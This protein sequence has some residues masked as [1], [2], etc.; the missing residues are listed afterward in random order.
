MHTFYEIS[1]GWR[2][3]F[4]GQKN[5]KKTLLEKGS[6]LKMLKMGTEGL[7]RTKNNHFEETREQI[8]LQKLVKRR[9]L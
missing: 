4:S 2:V 8:G 7:S 3:Q 9:F 6:N 5:L 1:K